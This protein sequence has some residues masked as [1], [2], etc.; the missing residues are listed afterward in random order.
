MRNR[1]QAGETQGS[2]TG[3]VHQ[4]NGVVRRGAQRVADLRAWMPRPEVTLLALALLWT[5]AAKFLVVRAQS[6]VEL[7]LPFV[8][9]VLP[10]LVFFTLVAG[11]LV[12]LQ[13]LPWRRAMARTALL[14]SG[15]VLGWALLNGAWLITTGV[16]L[17]P[18]VLIV[19][20]R[21]SSDMWALATG[22]MFRKPLYL[23]AVAG[24]VFVAGIWF[25]LRLVRPVVVQ[26]SWREV[27][28]RVA[29]HGAVALLLTGALHLSHRPGRIAYSGQII[30]FSSHWYAI[31]NLVREI[32]EGDISAEARDLPRAGERSIGM[33]AVSTS[34]LPNVFVIML[35]SQSFRETSMADPSLDLTPG[36]AKFASEGVEFRRTYMPI[37]QTTKAFW[38]IFTGM[39][40]EVLA[41]YAEA[42][43]ADEPYESLATILAR[44]G[45]PSAFFQ[46][47][48]G[49]FESLPAFFA[50]TG[51]DLAWFFED[52][53]RPETQVTMLS[54]DDFAM[55]D[56]MFAWVD[57]QSRPFLLTTITSIAHDP[58]LVPEWYRPLAEQ[59]D[60]RYGRFLLSLEYQDRWLTEVLE[61][62]DARGLRENSIVVVLGDHGESFRPESRR[63]RW[64]IFEE[65]VRIPMA[66]RWPAVIEPGRVIHET[67][68]AFDLTPT[69]LA[70][71][72]FEISDAGFDGRDMLGALPENRRIYLSAWHRNSPIGFVEGDRKVIYWPSTDVMFEY[73]LQNDPDETDPVTLR[74]SRRDELLRDIMQW[75]QSTHFDI[76]PRR[77]REAVFFDAWQVF[78]TGRTG[79]SFFVGGEDQ[80][81]GDARRD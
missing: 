69:L 46:M 67:C 74:G 7:L 23:I 73:D 14:V 72:G 2:G 31:M 32:G 53:R 60:D 41:G 40:P 30:G 39:Y 45:Y 12:M 70:L 33:P 65:L 16:Q 38:T 75:Q 61:R 36:L 8:Q 1:A 76:P 10:D 59:P 57:A 79:R 51:F 6:P 66:I 64:G 43:I 68:A 56:T 47:S 71:M 28:V 25:L 81:K 44:T 42:V 18:G 77:F 48:T 20:T 35:E 22:Y 50:N 24:T 3:S 58:F 17:Q 62:I 19:L 11:V 13:C 80:P 26:R 49:T 55:L 78:S 54:G 9:A 37:P 21:T 27:V 4:S 15:L 63:G 5:V 29:C 34:D 52:L